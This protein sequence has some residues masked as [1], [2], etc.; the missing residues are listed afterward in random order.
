M[1]L[2]FQYH[3]N[4]DW[5]HFVLVVIDY[6][7]YHLDHMEKKVLEWMKKNLLWRIK[8]KRLEGKIV[9]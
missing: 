3:K 4:V 9:S 7:F 1:I 8:K 6:N 5:F 2:V